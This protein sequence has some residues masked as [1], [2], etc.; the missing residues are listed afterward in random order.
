MNEV[1]I[2]GHHYYPVPML[3]DWQEH[4]VVIT[5]HSGGQIYVR[6]DEIARPV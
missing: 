3:R 4:W 2:D 1:I 6:D 5:D